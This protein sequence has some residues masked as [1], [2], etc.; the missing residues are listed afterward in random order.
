MPTSGQ[1][2]GQVFMAWQN[3]KREAERIAAERGVTLEEA[4]RAV[5][6]D[7]EL[8]SKCHSVPRAKDIPSD[9]SDPTL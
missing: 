2:R 8:V 1:R 5:F 3:V 6:A 4:E 9:W 7:P